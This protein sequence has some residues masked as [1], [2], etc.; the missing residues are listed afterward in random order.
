MN[1]E[2][3]SGAKRSTPLPPGKAVSS[4][5]WAWRSAAWAQARSG[6]SA[7]LG[8]GSKSQVWAPCLPP[9]R[10]HCRKN[11]TFA[12][13]LSLAANGA[14]LS[15]AEPHISSR[16]LEDSTPRRSGRGLVGLEGSIRAGSCRAKFVGMPRATCR[17]GNGWPRSPFLPLWSSPDD[18][19]CQWPSLP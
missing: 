3:G 11:L 7:R 14:L 17:H 5:S 12:I 18:S 8:A 13:R 6:D 16:M 2:S 10:R 1:N 19:G 15:C 4:Q 9:R